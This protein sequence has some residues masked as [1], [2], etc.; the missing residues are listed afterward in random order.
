MKTPITTT[1]IHPSELK[2]N[3]RA[4]TEELKRIRSKAKEMR[5]L[6]LTRRAL[7]M[8]IANKSTS[9]KTIINI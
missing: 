8:N 4:A 5:K 9:E 6:H 3:L 2:R 1:W 7:A